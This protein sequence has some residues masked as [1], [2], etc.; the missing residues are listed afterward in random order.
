MDK[1]GKIYLDP[2]DKKEDKNDYSVM[3]KWV[4]DIRMLID[5]DGFN[6]QE[7]SF[8]CVNIMYFIKQCEEIA[9]TLDETETKRLVTAR[10]TYLTMN[11]AVRHQY[12][13]FKRAVM[14][15]NE[16]HSK[17]D[18]NYELELDFEY[19][20]EKEINMIT[21]IDP[22][23]LRANII[24]ME[25]LWLCTEFSPLRFMQDESMKEFMP[26]F[27]EGILNAINSVINL[28]MCKG[29]TGDSFKKGF[30]DYVNCSRVGRLRRRVEKRLSTL[31]PLYKRF[32][33]KCISRMYKIAMKY[34]T[35]KEENP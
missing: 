33:K 32:E 6:D 28:C 15:L 11:S 24:S 17:W 30:F 35:H 25:T 20:K 34:Y 18:M 26:K 21:L 31:L 19:K 14:I 16:L 7:F 22:E 8:Q 9:E 4:S 23:K 3:N 29:A 2:E 1:K 10:N 13:V 12:K 5:S 27:Q